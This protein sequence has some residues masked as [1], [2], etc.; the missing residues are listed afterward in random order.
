MLI[1]PV[2][3]GVSSSRA[4]QTEQFLLFGL[5]V[6]AP[7]AIWFGIP[8]TP[9]ISLSLGRPD[10]VAV[11]PRPSEAMRLNLAFF[12]PRFRLNMS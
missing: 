5:Y 7:S 12:R 1:M 11:A 9:V 6:I 8:V 3:P 2:R 10:Q 4:W